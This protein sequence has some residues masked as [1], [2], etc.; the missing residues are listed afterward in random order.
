LAKKKSEVKVDTSIANVENESEKKDFDLHYIPRNFARS[1][2]QPIWSQTP[3]N[4]KTQAYT[5]EKIADFLKNPHATYKQLQGV[6]NYLMYTSPS[7]NNILDYLAN[8]MTFDYT[9]Y[10]IDAKAVTKITLQNRIFTSAE[11]VSKM[12]VKSI[13]PQMVKRALANGECYFYNLG[14]KNNIIIEEID[15]NLCQL[16]MIDDNNIWRF[17]INL[18]LIDA[19]RVAE[20]PEEIRIEYKKW[21]DGGKSKDKIE[22][23]GMVVPSYLYLVSN[24]GFSIFAHMRKIQHD[25][26]YLA[27]MFEDLNDL[28]ADKTYMTEYIKENNIKLIHLKVPVDKDSGLPLF[29]KEIIS[30]YHDSA[31]EHLPSNVAPLTNPFEVTAIALD[32]S[33][34]TAINLVDHSTNVVS[35]DSGI[36]KAIFNAE[37]TNGLQY[38]TL[39]DVSK[40]YPLLYF[41]ENFINLQIKDQ[42]CKVKFLRMS[43]YNQSSMHEESRTDLLS[44]GSRMLFVATGGIELYDFLHMNATEDVLDFDDMLEAKLNASQASA[45]DLQNKNGRP[46][47]SGDK[48]ADSTVKVKKTQ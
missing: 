6:S 17:Y 19:N 3:G 40:L 42:K 39:A 7:Y 45:A 1:H 20:L 46:A 21:I 22:V 44:G 16:A 12:N 15:S 8:A 14:D 10:G 29:S 34:S 4:A 5:S 47:V 23:D 41:F 25:Y 31:K 38:S 28:E 37:T 27:A 11:V 13:F 9:L 35:D 18:S 32:K 33:Q 30:I 43:H 2:I 24:R 26:P 48:Q 36:S